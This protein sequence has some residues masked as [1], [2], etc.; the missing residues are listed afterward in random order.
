ML[1]GQ[2]LSFFSKPLQRRYIT[3]AANIAEDH[4]DIALPSF[5]AQTA[6]GCAG[7]MLLEGRV[8]PVQ[9]RRR[10]GELADGKGAFPGDF[11]HVGSTGTHQGTHH[12]RTGGRL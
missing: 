8:I 1:S 11:L 9:G 10:I 12:N 3:C 2:R 7:K 6:H 4:T 5:E